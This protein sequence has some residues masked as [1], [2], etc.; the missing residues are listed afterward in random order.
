[1]TVRTSEGIE[2]GILD[3]STF[4]ESLRAVP[5][6]TA[7]EVN[8]KAQS[9]I[10]AFASS[11]KEAATIATRVVV[12]VAPEVSVEGIPCLRKPGLMYLK[13]PTSLSLPLVEALFELL[14]F[15]VLDIVLDAPETGSADGTEGKPPTSLPEAFF[16]ILGFVFPDGSEAG[17]TDGTE[18]RSRLLVARESKAPSRRWWASYCFLETRFPRSIA[19]MGGHVAPNR[20]PQV[21]GPSSML[22]ICYCVAEAGL[23]MAD[24]LL[25][26]LAPGIASAAATWLSV[27]VEWKETGLPVRST[28]PKSVQALFTP[29]R[30]TVRLKNSTEP[31]MVAIELHH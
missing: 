14:D 20:G 19:P 25:G 26:A 6:T 1:M 27:N 31:Q 21:R 9:V 13:L 29:D 16:V 17:S 5:T 30:D 11:R 15:V 12:F 28:M 10:D 22:D 2:G 24:Y 7:S 4:D 23:S 18:G 3:L 8:K